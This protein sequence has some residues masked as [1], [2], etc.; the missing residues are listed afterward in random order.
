MFLFSKKFRS[1]LLV[2][3]LVFEGEY[4]SAEGLALCWECNG[5]GDGIFSPGCD[6]KHDGNDAA[7]ETPNHACAMYMEK[8]TKGVRPILPSGRMIQPENLYA[9]PI[10]NATATMRTVVIRT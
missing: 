5:D 3:A 10:R 2:M 7:C 8:G 9:S 4:H 1:L 6:D